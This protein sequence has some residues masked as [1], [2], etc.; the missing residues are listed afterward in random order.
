[1]LILMETF[2]NLFSSFPILRPSPFENSDFLGKFLP[3][4]HPIILNLF[5]QFLVSSCFLK[6]KKSCLK[7][8]YILYSLIPFKQLRNFFSGSYTV[9]LPRFF[10]SGLL[11]V[12]NSHIMDLPHK[13]DVPWLP[14]LI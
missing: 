14:V 13:S 2:S 5:L 12:P 4:S 7:N 3:F 9:F 6:K 10:F 11:F 1:M 8:T